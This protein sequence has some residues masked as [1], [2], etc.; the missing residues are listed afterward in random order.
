V[1]LFKY[2]LP[3]HCYAHS[4]WH[5]LCAY[6]QPIHCA[7]LMHLR[8]FALLACCAERRHG[9]QL[10]GIN[11]I[12]EADRPRQATASCWARTPILHLFMAIWLQEAGS[13]PADVSEQQQRYAFCA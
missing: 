2:W 5:V 12:G 3:V 11:A 10:H 4:V 1:S 9:A 7:M 13:G 6:Q 8:W